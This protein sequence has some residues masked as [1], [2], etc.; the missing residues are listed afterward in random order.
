MKRLIFPLALFL[1]LTSCK[2]TKIYY[3]DSSCLLVYHVKR[4]NRHKVFQNISEHGK[5]SVA[6]FFGLN[7]NLVINNLGE[8][9]AF[10]ITKSNKNDGKGSVSLLETLTGLAFSDKGYIVKNCLMNY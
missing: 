9:I 5:T 3:F 4:S 2:N 7:L 8:L 1:Q 6:W 10:K